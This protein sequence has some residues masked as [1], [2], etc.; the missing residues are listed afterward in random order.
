MTLPIDTVLPDI[1]AAL[2]RSHCAVIQAPPGSGKT[3][4]VPLA[5]L[6]EVWPG[7]VMLEPRWLADNLGETVPGGFQAGLRLISFLSSA[8]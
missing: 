2:S 5:L 3:T 7:I 4:R 6:D 8:F 1:Q